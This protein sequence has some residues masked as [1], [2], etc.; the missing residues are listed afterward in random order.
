MLETEEREKKWS[1]KLEIKFHNMQRKKNLVLGYTE[2]EKKRAKISPYQ[3][4]H[5]KR[6]FFEKEQTCVIKTRELQQ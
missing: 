4:L 3:G 2:L 6:N 1:A 5:G